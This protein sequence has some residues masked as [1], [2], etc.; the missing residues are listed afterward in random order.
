MEETLAEEE[1]LVEMEEIPTEEI[2]AEEEA[3]IEAEEPVAE[4]EAT[5][6]PTDDLII[7]SVTVGDEMNENGGGHIDE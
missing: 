5:A 4:A 6:E 7:E 1:I 2:P 3:T